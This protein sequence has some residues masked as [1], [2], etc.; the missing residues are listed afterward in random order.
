VLLFVNETPVLASI[1]G[2]LRGLVSEIRVEKNEKIGDIE[3][4]GDVSYCRTISDKARAI[5][6]GVLEAVLHYTAK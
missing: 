6:G 1:N 3:P 2:I 5:A 4:G